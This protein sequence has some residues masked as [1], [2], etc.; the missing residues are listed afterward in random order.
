MTWSEKQTNV[1]ATRRQIWILLWYIFRVSSALERNAK[2]LPTNSMQFEIV[3]DHTGIRKGKVGGYRAKPTGRKIQIFNLSNTYERRRN[4]DSMHIFRDR[5]PWIFHQWLNRRS[6]FLNSTLLI[7]LSLT[8][9]LYPRY[10][11]VCRYTFSRSVDKLQ[12]NWRTGLKRLRSWY[13]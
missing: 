11:F 13:R 12:L 6:P 9:E 2:P 10:P 3:A 8:T 4:L 7:L 1:S 5:S